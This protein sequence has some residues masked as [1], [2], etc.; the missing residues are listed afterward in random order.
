MPE[1]FETPNAP[2]MDECDLEVA[3]IM[4]AGPT[5]QDSAPKVFRVQ[6]AVMPIASL[7]SSV[8]GYASSP[9]APGSGMGLR[10]HRVACS[11]LE[12]GMYKGA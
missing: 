3:R 12:P 1:I 6:A 11:P 8:G 7:L 4:G 2:E 10:G 9:S 5:G